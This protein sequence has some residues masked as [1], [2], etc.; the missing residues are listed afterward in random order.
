M[1]LI[2]LIDLSSIKIEIFTIV[3]FFF[4]NELYRHALAVL[5]C[6]ECFILSGSF[7]VSLSSV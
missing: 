2:C 5:N 7:L 4:F 3:F 1:T 6:R